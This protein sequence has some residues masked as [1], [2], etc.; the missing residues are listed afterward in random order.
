MTTRVEESAKF[1]LC[2]SR[3]EHWCTEVID[4]QKTAGVTF[5]IPAVNGP[6]LHIWLAGAG[7]DML[8]NFISQV[9]QTKYGNTQQPPPVGRE[10]M[11]ELMRSGGIV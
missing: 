9:R 2:V 4:S 1:T 11:I 8:D 6:I 10:L 7:S 3:C 5:F